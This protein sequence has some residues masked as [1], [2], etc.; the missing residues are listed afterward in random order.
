MDICFS[1]GPLVETSATS[2]NSL[3]WCKGLGLAHKHASCQSVESR[4][5]AARKKNRVCVC[6]CDQMWWKRMRGSR[7]RP[8]V[9]HFDALHVDVFHVDV[10]RS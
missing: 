4:T 2:C 6:V 10:L 1:P 7:C 3:A 8:R 9:M 5:H